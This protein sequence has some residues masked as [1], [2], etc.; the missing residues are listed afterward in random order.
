MKTYYTNSEQD[1]T[2]LLAKGFTFALRRGYPRFSSEECEIISKHKT[3]EA[4]VKAS[5]GTN[6]VIDDI[7]YIAIEFDLKNNATRGKY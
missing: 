3:Y 4:A 5:H 6:H 2:E 7:K 1:I